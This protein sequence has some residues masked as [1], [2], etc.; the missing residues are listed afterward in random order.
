MGEYGGEEEDAVWTEHG[1][2]LVGAE[3]VDLDAHGVEGAGEEEADAE[4]YGEEDAGVHGCDGGCC[5]SAR[6]GRFHDI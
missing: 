6:G 1:V 3:E 4:F 2:E 5:G